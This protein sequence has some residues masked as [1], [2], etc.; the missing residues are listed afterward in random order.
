MESSL[1]AMALVLE[2]EACVMTGFWLLAVGR[3]RFRLTMNG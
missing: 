1:Q 2:E 3:W